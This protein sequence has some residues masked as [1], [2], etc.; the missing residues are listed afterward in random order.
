MPIFLFKLQAARV[1]TLLALAAALLLGACS[2]TPP[3]R[4]R[5]SAWPGV[6]T[7]SDEQAHDIAIHALGLVGTPYRYGGN[8]PES[9]FDC[10]GLIGY[11]YRLR[12]G[13]PPPRTVAQL[14]Q[15]GQPI[16]ASE[17]RTGDLV[18]FGTGRSPSHAG[19][20]VGEGRFVHA[21]STGGTVRMDDLQS[22]HW[23]RQN[24]AFRRP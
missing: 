2:S 7:L 13:T 10:S 22:R 6:S 12:V 16:D 21:P 24:P 14:N 19:I 4:V 11:V 9:G 18:V 20:Y 23:S 8:T 3:A 15:W 1:P 5:P 17:L